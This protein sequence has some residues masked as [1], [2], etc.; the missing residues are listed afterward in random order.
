MP[1]TNI[2]RDIRARVQ[3]Q[4]LPV[5]PKRW[6][7]QFNFGIQAFSLRTF[8]SANGNAR[9]VVANPS[10]ASTK[11]DRLLANLK[12]AKHLGAVFDALGLV[13]QSS[14]VNIDYSDMNGLMALV[15]AVQT[16]KGRAI[17]CVVETTYSDRLPAHAQAPPRK[18]ALRAAR[19][20]ERRHFN[21]TTHTIRCLKN[22]RKR[23]GFWPQLVF[24]RG[25]CSEELIRL[26]CKRKA[27]FYVRMK[28]GRLVELAGERIAANTLTGHDNT[29]QLYGFRLRVIRSRKPKDGEPWYILTNDL[30]RTTKKILRIYRHRFEIEE[31]FKDM[32]HIFELRRTRLNQPNSLK[33]ILWLVSIGIALLYLATKCGIANNR[34]GNPKKWRS[35]VRAAYEQ[36]EQAQ[37]AMLWSQATEALWG[38]VVK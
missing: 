37:T 7:K 9:K 19:T 29:V 15:G 10:T 17:P 22:L 33:V 35:W 36:L 21:L 12:L 16:R 32:K 26:L 18:Q 25:F 31:T 20:K 30:T 23:L 28:A 11:T 8:S 4:L 24:D 6:S 13:H 5:L 38:E 34:W 3:N 27:T 14:F 1:P 2:V